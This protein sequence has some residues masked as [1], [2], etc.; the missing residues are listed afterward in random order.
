MSTYFIIFFTTAQQILPGGC[1]P[2]PA[3]P[4]HPTTKRP[5]C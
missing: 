2:T 5:V 1:N 3:T 4:S